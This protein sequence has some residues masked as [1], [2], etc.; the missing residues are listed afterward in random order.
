MLC[1]KVSGDFVL[2]GVRVAGSTLHSDDSTMELLLDLTY[3]IKT[4]FGLFG[5]PGMRDPQFRL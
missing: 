2:S 5:V 3:I 1:H 4:C